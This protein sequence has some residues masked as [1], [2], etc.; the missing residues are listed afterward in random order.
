MAVQNPDISQS[1]RDI[2]KVKAV[3]SRFNVLPAVLPVFN[4]PYGIP[5]IMHG[6]YSSAGAPDGWKTLITVPDNEMWLVHAAGYS[7]A[8]GDGNVDGLAV[9][10]PIAYA[11][12]NGKTATSSRYVYLDLTADVTSYHPVLLGNA[13]P[14]CEG[15][16]FK[17]WHDFNTVA[18]SLTL[19]L[20]V[21]RFKW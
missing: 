19:D 20:L 3:P 18:D 11:L 5:W 4:V 1:I 12:D 2:L 9:F 10:F 13:F 21:T 16:I 8:T 6:E 14:V 17:L 7:C 15:A